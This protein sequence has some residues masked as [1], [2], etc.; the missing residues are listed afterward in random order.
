MVKPKTITA[1]EKAPN[2]ETRQP[3]TR[4]PMAKAL[5]RVS[6]ITTM[7]LSFAIPIAA[8]SY[9]DSY[10]ETGLTFTLILFVLGGLIAAVQL[11]KLI[12]DLEQTADE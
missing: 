1:T 5:H 8:G 7:S 2:G 9:L 11:R 6:Q 12:I 3:D 4:S 10:L